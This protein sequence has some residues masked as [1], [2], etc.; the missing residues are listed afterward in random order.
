MKK[1]Y[2][3]WNKKKIATSL[4]VNIIETLNN[5][6]KNRLIYNFYIK[7]IKLKIVNWM[8]SFFTNKL[9]ILKTNK[10]ILEKIYILNR[11]T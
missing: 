4:F 11:I 8:N 10:Y 7:K 5:V 3:F 9:I 1:V 2:T 6:L